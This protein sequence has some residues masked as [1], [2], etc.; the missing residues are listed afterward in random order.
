MGSGFSL[1]KGAHVTPR[2]CQVCKSV[3]IYKHGVVPDREEAVPGRAA[4][5]PAPRAGADPDADGRGPGPFAELP[6]PARAQPAAGD[7]AGA[8][9]PG[10]DLRP[11][12]QD[13]V[14]GSGVAQ[15]AGAGGGVR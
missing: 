15:F 5:T 14:V 13:A 7:G 8:V 11:G 1:P 3:T 2:S 9:A 12:P 10:R 4:E 6:E